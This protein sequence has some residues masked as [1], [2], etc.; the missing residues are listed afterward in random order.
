MVLP[1]PVKKIT[2]REVRL[3]YELILGR[4]PENDDVVRAHVATGGSLRTLREELLRSQEFH[5]K[6]GASLAIRSPA[7]PPI[8]VEVDASAEVLARLFRRVESNRS[9]LGRQ[10]PYWSVL[11]EDRFKS[12]SLSAE[13]I[14]RFYDSGK[15]AL[16]LFEVVTRR[17]GIDL[18]LYKSAFELGCGV[19]RVTTSLVT[20]FHTV[21]AAD[22]SLP[23]L[24]IAADQTRART[25]NDRVDW[26]QLKSPRDLLAV[27]PFD[28]FYSVI[29]LQH[30]PPPLIDFLL[31]TVLSKIKSG[32]IA[33]F[34]VQTYDL[35]YRFSVAEYLQSAKSEGKI[36]MHVLPQARL[37]R[38]LSDANCDLLEVREDASTAN[39]SGISNTVLARKR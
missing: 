27:K 39:P 24:K 10:E 15:E 32:G 33:Y 1:I 5:S 11:A 18:G 17:S 12:A 23:H 14:D 2:E 31:S 28:M 3:A 35:G 34:Q 38:I 19:G 13:N 30:N 7:W 4:L 20:K 21:C 37:W 36:E 22:V 16:A 8:D 9:E 25:G 29:V 6:V 26:L